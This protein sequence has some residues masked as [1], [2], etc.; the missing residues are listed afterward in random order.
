[1]KKEKYMIIG[2]KG[3]YLTGYRFRRISVMAESHLQ[4]VPGLTTLQGV[5]ATGIKK[6]DRLAADGWERITA[7]NVPYQPVVEGWKAEK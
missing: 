6:L 7:E 4:H 5:S 1:M 3:D 2:Q